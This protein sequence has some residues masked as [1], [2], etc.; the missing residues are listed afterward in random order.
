V[1]G[2]AA[3]GVL[4]PQAARASANPLAAV[5]TARRLMITGDTPSDS[6]TDVRVMDYGHRCT[7]RRKCVELRAQQ[8]SWER[9]VLL[10]TGSRPNSVAV[11]PCGAWQ[12]C[13]GNRSRTDWTN[14]DR[15][16]NVPISGVEC[17]F[18]ARVPPGRCSAGLSGWASVFFAEP[19]QGAAG[20]RP[21][22]G[23]P[24]ASR[25]REGR[26]RFH[27]VVVG[28]GHCGHQSDIGCLVE[29]PRRS[30]HRPRA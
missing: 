21:G 29:F 18:A 20:R 28:I 26:G 17:A 25:L 9:N 16:P 30:G 12:E 13:F 4:D 14:T 15:H 2:P 22:H 11:G 3:V 1:V 27:S 6:D 8:W 10:H 19:T 23:C 5:R 7:R 24:A